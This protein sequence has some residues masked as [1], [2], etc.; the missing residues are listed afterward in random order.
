VI[1]SDEH[2]CVTCS[3]DVVPMRLVEVRPDGVGVCDGGVE[4]M[5]DLVGHV[6]PGDVLLVH[7]GV[8]LQPAERPEPVLP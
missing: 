1:C 6:R 3:D 2:H 5:L 7:A 4:V 8:A